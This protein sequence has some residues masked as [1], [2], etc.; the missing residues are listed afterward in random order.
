ML[1]ALLISMR[2]TCFWLAGDQQDE[3]PASSPQRLFPVDEVCMVAGWMPSPEADYAPSSG[4]ENY[5]DG[6]SFQQ[7]TKMAARAGST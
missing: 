6:Y 7:W 5:C 3:N 2:H 1:L 4:E